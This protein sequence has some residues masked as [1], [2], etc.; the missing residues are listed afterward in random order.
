MASKLRVDSILPVD[1]APTDG[2]G[3]IVQVVYAEDNNADSL[4]AF[5][6]SGA[7]SPVNIMS[8]TI[9]PKF[10]TSKVLLMVSLGSLSTNA[11]SM[12]F[13]L[14]RGSTQIGGATSTANQ[15]GF[16]NV[17]AAA[18]FIMSAY[19]N[20]LDSPSTTSATT[21]KLQWRVAS[22]TG[23]LGQWKDSTTDYNGSSTITAMEVSA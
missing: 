12:G 5:S 20:F 15:S 2:G 16:T 3:G 14:L 1:G 9:T 21:Y 18:A 22:G 7:D 13:R 23:Y 6:N 11:Q 10:S 17:Y 8:A 19:H 4:G